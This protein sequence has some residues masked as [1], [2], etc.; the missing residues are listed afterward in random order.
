MNAFHQVFGDP[1]DAALW[2][3][4]DPLALADAADP[5]TVPG[6]YFDCGEQDRYGLFRGNGDLDR[7]L[8]AR[9][10]PHTFGLFPGNHGYEYVH[11][12]LEKSLR[13]LGGALAPASP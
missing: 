9:K 7:R 6:L 11:T 13:F 5:K 2:H 8:E 4:S 1:I 12:V 3:A 10:V